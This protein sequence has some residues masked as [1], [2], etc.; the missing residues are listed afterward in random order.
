MAMALASQAAT[1]TIPPP[2]RLS[3]SCT[4]QGCREN[5]SSFGTLCRGGTAPEKLA[6]GD[7]AMECSACRPSSRACPNFV[8]SCSL[9]TARRRL[10]LILPLLGWHCWV[11]IILRRLCAR[12]GQKG[13]APF[14]T[15]GR[16]SGVSHHRAS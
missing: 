11:L 10:G 15:S 16:R 13:G 4:K 12:D 9:G 8:S 5:R 3:T 2:R 1:T 7:C 6:G 14:Q